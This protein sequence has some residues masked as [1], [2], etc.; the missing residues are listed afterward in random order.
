MHIETNN[1]DFTQVINNKIFKKKSTNSYSIILHT[2]IEGK[3]YYL[4]AQ[5]RD[6]ITFKE[7][8]KC[9]IKDNEI[10]NYM[11]HIS[12]EEMYRL[13][14]ES[15]EDLLNDTILDRETHVYKTSLN[16]QE[17]FYLNVNKFKNIL[18][19]KSIGL[20]EAPW[21]FPKGRKEITNGFDVESDINCA[22]REFEEETHIKKENIKIYNNDPLEETY[23]GIDK[24]IYKTIYFLGFLDYSIFQLLKVEIKSK[25]IVT[26]KR[27]SL[28]EEIGKIKLLTYEEAINKLDKPKRYIL[29]IMNNYL[30]FKLKRKIIQRRHSC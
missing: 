4:L 8:I 21:I 11:S 2:L 12:K 18:L 29:R 20:K 1:E 3:I 28:S 13:L 30:I 23:F 27:I 25:F 10:M 17:K 16:L 14:S 26:S 19:D 9:N 24:N 6:S 15:F 5:V 7:F 22:L